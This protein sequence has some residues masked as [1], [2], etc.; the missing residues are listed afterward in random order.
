MNGE[1]E[2]LE[3]MI[4]EYEKAYEYLNVAEEENPYDPDVYYMMTNTLYQLKNYIGAIEY[5]VKSQIYKKSISN[6]ECIFY[7]ENLCKKIEQDFYI[8]SNII[9]D[10]TEEKVHDNFK[11]MRGPYHAE[12]RNAKGEIIEDME[13]EKYFEN[14]VFE[15]IGKLFYY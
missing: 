8:I 7:D 10:T 2:N 9:Q 6:S 13:K 12:L 5:G 11:I 4:E 15:H 14:I 3:K 1:L